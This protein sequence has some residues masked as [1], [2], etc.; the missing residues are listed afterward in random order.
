MNITL[1]ADMDMLRRTREYAKQH[2]TSLNQLVRD[3]MR[4]LTAREELDK[5]ADEFVRNAME[6][7]GCS[8]EGFRFSRADAQRMRD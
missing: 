2:G 5:A 6:H 8:P 1:S 7:G 3:F 4:S